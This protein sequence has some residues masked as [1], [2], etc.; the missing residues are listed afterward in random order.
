V[1]WLEGFGDDALLQTQ[2]LN[3]LRDQSVIQGRG[4]E[5]SG[6]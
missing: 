5:A 2:A 4:A 3:W 1:H 6:V